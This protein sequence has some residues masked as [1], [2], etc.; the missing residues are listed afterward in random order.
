M[1]KPL[2]LIAV[3][4]VAPVAVGGAQSGADSPWAPWFGCWTPMAGGSMD[5]SITCVLPVPEV[6]TEAT[7][8]VVRDGALVRRSTLRADGRQAEIAADGCSGWEAASVSEDGARIYLRGEVTC[9]G[10]ARQAT[11]GVFALSRTGEW[12]DIQGVWTGAQHAL[13]ATR[14]RSVPWYSLPEVVGAELGGLER[15]V[16][17]A[18]SAAATSVTL[19]RI[20]E[21]AAQLDA[22]VAEA[23]L[24]ESAVDA[25]RRLSVRRGELERLEAA[26]VPTRVIDM[27]VALGNPERFQVAV[28]APG[29]GA[30]QQGMRL[31][32]T[33]V[34]RVGVMP[35][36]WWDHAMLPNCGFGGIGMWGTPMFWGDC[37]GLAGYSRMGMLGY[38][39]FGNYPGWFGGFGWPV[40][41]AVV[42]VRP[43]SG[44]TPTTGGRVVRG[45]GYT[46][47]GSST[48]GRS[49]SPRAETGGATVRTPSGGASSG[50]ASAQGSGGRSSGGAAA[51]SG[52]SGSSG[53]S[54]RTAKP[55]NP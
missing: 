19:D 29:R 18:R 48:G 22:P 32:V 40:T 39:Q 42:P 50:G 55:R 23:W 33:G 16:T 46:Q 25:D 6:P 27:V 21:A 17:V 3:L 37:I 44:A 38:G 5:G 11:S 12:I 47:G 30:V 15:A 1:H 52:S 41:F 28:T 10:R 31:P 8:A 43:P 4:F 24:V 45:A 35:M 14:F 36:G 26:Q 2:T 53:S 51:A 7:I 54:G 9:G 34:G 13:R 49:A 20:I